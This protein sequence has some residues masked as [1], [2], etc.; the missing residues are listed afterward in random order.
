MSKAEFPP[1][2]DEFMGEQNISPKE[3]TAIQDK[4]KK[5]EYKAEHDL[6]IQRI[7]EDK[8]SIEEITRQATEAAKK[9]QNA[10]HFPAQEVIDV[11]ATLEDK[12]ET[13]ADEE[14]TRV[15]NNLPDGTQPY[16]DL[17]T[18]EEKQ[19]PAKQVG[20]I[21]KIALAATMF[22]TGLF[23]AKAANTEKGAEDSAKNKIE[24]VTSTKS[25]LMD[26]LHKTNKLTPIERQEEI[27]GIKLEGMLYVPMKDTT[28]DYYFVQF[29]GN[30]KDKHKIG[31]MKEA[32]NKLG[33]LPGTPQ[34]MDQALSLHGE[35]L[36]KATGGYGMSLVETQEGIDDT[37]ASNVNIKHSGPKTNKLQTFNPTGLGEYEEDALDQYDMYPIMVKVK[38]TTV[39]LVAN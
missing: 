14:I 6:S 7:S 5:L 32:I 18:E 15:V 28:Y 13:P 20:G 10:E 4:I 3:A 17:R 24:S 22:L 19:S 25:N 34:E 21:K 1:Q 31:K 9:T 37:K 36:K 29:S 2:D 16:E 38:R 8:R 30:S 35:K 39:D 23:G 11:P 12:Y 33:F 27:A 26:S